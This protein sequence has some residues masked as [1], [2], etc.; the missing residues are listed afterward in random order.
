MVVVDIARQ[1]WYNAG[2]GN[3]TYLCYLVIFIVP[4]VGA[5]L[6]VIFRRHFL[7]ERRSTL[8]HTCACILPR[9]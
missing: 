1:A 8:A 9:A 4:L 2:M 5:F 7:F 6:P 3:T